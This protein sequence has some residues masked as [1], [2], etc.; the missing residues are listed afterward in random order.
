[1]KAIIAWTSP[2]A[3]T[4]ARGA[5]WM[6][7][8]RPVAA[9]D[10]IRIKDHPV[11]GL[12]LYRPSRDES[13]ALRAASGEKPSEAPVVPPPFSRTQR[14]SPRQLRLEFPGTLSPSDPNQRT[15]LDDR[16]NPRSPAAGKAGAPDASDE[17]DGDWDRR[18]Q[19]L[20]ESMT[21]GR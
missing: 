11:P 12:A 14:P 13:G 3:R 17:P 6:H 21:A 9:P 4:Q 8:H 10:W 2:E 15:L 7:T 1:V 16:G 18:L 19:Q 5:G 20:E